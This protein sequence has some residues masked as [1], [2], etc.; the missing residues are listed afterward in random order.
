M[1]ADALLKLARAYA[2]ATGQSLRAVG[3][4]S[5]GNDK[6]FNRLAAGRGCNILT[7]ERAA[8]WLFENW[9][10]GVPWPK[11]VAR[12]TESVPAGDAAAA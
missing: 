4:A 3:V 11:D 1:N 5:C 10:A 2:E 7:A 9:P 6:I 8:E 12:L